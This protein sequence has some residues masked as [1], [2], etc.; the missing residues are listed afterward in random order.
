MTL[1]QASAIFLFAHQDDETGILQKILDE[2]MCNRKVLCVYLTNDTQNRAITVRRNQESVSV[3]TKL[4]VSRENII[5]AGAEL[6]IHDGDLLNHLTQAH[7]WLETFLSKQ[8]SI[9]ALYLPAWEGGH[10][11]HDALHA[12]GVNVATCIGIDKKTQQFPLYNALNCFGPFFRVLLPLEANGPTTS[13]KVSW[14]NRFSFLRY[15]L[16]Y[17]SQARSWVGLFPFMF[18]HYMIWGVQFTQPVSISRTQQ[19]PHS[20]PLYYERRKYCTYGKLDEV[21][22]RVLPLVVSSSTKS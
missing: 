8:R 10:H 22:K 11:D 7:L 4:G 19:R 15:C 14:S 12:L 1:N 5:F 18:F 6:H 2:V 9:S 17:P 20:G 13:T 16:S 21:L 3:L